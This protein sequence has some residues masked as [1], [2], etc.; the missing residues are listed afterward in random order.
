MATVEQLGELVRQMGLL[1][2]AMMAQAQAVSTPVGGVGG[3]GGS[4][5]ERRIVGTKPF[6]GMKKFAKGEADWKEFQFDFSVI[7]GTEN[8]GLLR[9]LKG[10][11]GMTGEVTK[12]M[13]RE[14]DSNAADEVGL[15]VAAKE[16][17]QV[18][19]MVTDGEAKLIVK[20]SKEQDGVLAWS[21]LFGHYNRKTLARVLRVHR[22]AMHPKTIRDLGS[23]VSGIV[24]WED[25]WD[26][27]AK[28]HKG[29]LP[30]IWKL[31][32]FMEMCPPEA[33]EIIYQNV[34]QVDESYEKMKQ[35]VMAWVSNKVANSGP[36]PMDVGQVETGQWED[37]EV[38][39]DAVNGSMQCYNCGGWGHAART[40]PSERRG[41]GEKG[42]GKGNKG[43]GKGRD[44]GGQKGHYHEDKKGYQE[45][46]GGKGKGY[47][48]KCFTCGRVGHKAWECQNSVGAHAV[49]EEYD[50]N[51]VQAGAVEVGTIWSIG[52]VDVGKV[53]KKT[54]EVVEVT[55][56]SGV[57]ANCWPEGMLPEVP[58][59]PRALGVRFVAA[60]G[61]DL[62]YHG[63]KDI[64]F[65]AAE[66][67]GKG[68]VCQMQ[69]HVTNST[70]PLASAAAVVKAGNR[71]VF[72]PAGS[73]IENTRSK[74]RIRLR[75][76]NG[77]YVF[78]VVPEIDG[79]AASGFSRRG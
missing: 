30:V 5:A 25:K 34:D 41:K 21:R 59:K 73:F 13:A 32:A 37:E 27:M 31:A 70:K 67:G 38:N 1:S 16:L 48:G 51:E 53:E 68:T 6:L 74:E 57:G 24:A 20:N 72:D 14:L 19:C 12:T 47:Q 11:E 66:S 44:K 69:F 18:L 71:I 8:D 29:E 64:R 39:I 22:E 78:D 28:E 40:C 58:I 36:V 4:R 9:I 61:Q 49:S 54:S 75:E 46:G 15:E 43:G 42:G 77:T 79:K 52:A 55:L 45:K 2:Q 33:Q 60:N 23:I 63:R 35:R 62:A 3:S 65:R 50:Q 76:S 7:L 26:N 10:V 56:D 17:F